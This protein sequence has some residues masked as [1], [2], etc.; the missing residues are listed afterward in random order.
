MTKGFE[1]AA[2]I[3]AEIRELIRRMSREN[4]LEAGIQAQMIRMSTRHYSITALPFRL[5]LS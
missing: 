1:Y 2:Q 4:P 5:R 3:S